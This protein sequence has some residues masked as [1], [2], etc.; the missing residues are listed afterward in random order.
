MNFKYFKFKAAK[1][2][3]NNMSISQSY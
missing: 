1:D 2:Q 3:P